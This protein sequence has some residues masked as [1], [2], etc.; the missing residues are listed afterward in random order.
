M[1]RFQEDLRKDKTA[2]SVA[3]ILDT[4]VEGF[5][6]AKR[7]FKCAPD[8]TLC[9]DMSIEMRGILGGQ[10]KGILPDRIIVP[11]YAHT[12]H[13]ITLDCF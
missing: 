2:K 13:P 10:A 5:E 11:G 7:N 4:A 8:S 9:E 1:A 6:L 3:E 12:L